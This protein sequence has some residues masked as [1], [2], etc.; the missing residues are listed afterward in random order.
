[1]GIRNPEDLKKYRKH[2]TEDGL[3]SKISRVFRKAGQKVIYSALLLYYVLND[4][5]TPLEHKAVI[6]GALGYFI[7][8]LDILPDFIP[9]AGYADDIAALTACIKAVKS[10]IT[11][12]IKEKA[13][14]RASG[15]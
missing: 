13:S 7:L 15:G 1:M 8:P 9:F 14:K 3:F 4:S 5:K 12:E 10:N 6:I 11:P 2:Y